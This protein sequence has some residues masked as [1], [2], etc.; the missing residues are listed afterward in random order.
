MNTA[1]FLANQKA[2]FSHSYD[3]F[4]A[5]GG[6]CVYFHVECLRAGRDAFLSQ[7]H[8]EMLYAT[9]TAWGMHRMGNAET[10]KTKLTDWECFQA[11]L[12]STAS[13]LAEFRGCKLLEMSEGQYSEA[14]SRL[15]A[16]YQA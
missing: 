9:L 16:C 2:Y 5:F 13:A 15:R 4:R 1:Q 11:S 7:R 8:I 6:P 10:T 14:V 12:V 3:Q